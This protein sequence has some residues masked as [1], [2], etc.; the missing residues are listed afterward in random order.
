MWAMVSDMPAVGSDNTDGYDVATGRFVLNGADLGRRVV[1]AYRRAERARRDR[2][3]A[4]LTGHGIAHATIAGS[5]DIRRELVRLTEV[6]AR[7]G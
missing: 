7:A 4:F 1:A 3:N 6:S 5:H 2:L